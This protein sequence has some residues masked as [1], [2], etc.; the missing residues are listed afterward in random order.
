MNRSE[1]ADFQ[2]LL[3]LRWPNAETPP[4]P[5]LAQ[6]FTDLMPYEFPDAMEA[7]D[8]LHKE[9]RAF[10]P[11]TS[12]IRAKMT[13]A[14]RQRLE[15]ERRKRPALPESVDRRKGLEGFAQDHEGLGPSEYFRRL[16]KE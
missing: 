6:A 9:G 12:E 5:V 8:L 2:A 15:G 3:R 1:F 7:L 14:R 10:P 11:N 13:Y 16:A 4:D